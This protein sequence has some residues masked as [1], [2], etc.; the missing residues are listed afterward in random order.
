MKENEWNNMYKIAPNSPV[1][2]S[3]NDVNKEGDFEVT[4]KDIPGIVY[5]NNEDKERTL[6]FRLIVEGSDGSERASEAKQFIKVEGGELIR[7]SF[8]IYANNVAV[9]PG[10]EEAAG[11]TYI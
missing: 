5:G 11:K 6:R 10:G 2:N 3:W 9:S 1:F 4:I 7:N 8:T